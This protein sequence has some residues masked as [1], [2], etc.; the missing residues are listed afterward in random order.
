MG[1]ARIGLAVSDPLGITAQGDGLIDARSDF[2]GAVKEKIAFWSVSLLLI[3]FPINQDGTE[4]N[5]AKRIREL[6]SRIERE[7]NCPV[8][9]WDERF[10][11]KEAQRILQ[12]ENIDSR[13][14]KRMVDVMSAQIIL[15]SYLDNLALTTAISGQKTK[16]AALKSGA[17]GKMMDDKIL[18]VN[19]DGE[20]VEFTIDDMFDF[21]DKTYVV[22]CENDESEDALLFRIEDQGNN[23]VLLIE[24][25]DDDEFDRVSE[26]YFNEE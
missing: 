24:V 12:Y 18:L 11:T 3:G 5:K 7:T 16:V 15:Q 4:G 20:E 13:K 8:K 2:I 6:A 10:S 26:Y 1:E 19:E 14:Q 9:L 23:D 17:R 25:D 22:L 21:E